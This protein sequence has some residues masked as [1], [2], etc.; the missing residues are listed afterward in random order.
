MMFRGLVIV[1]AIEVQITAEISQRKAAAH[2]E[3][4]PPV[5]VSQRVI[6]RDR[7]V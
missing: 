1:E 3:V 4:R 5:L 6:S 2:T 7:G